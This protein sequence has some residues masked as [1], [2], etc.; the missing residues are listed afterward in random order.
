M[1]KVVQRLVFL[2]FA[3]AAVVA[4]T[5]IPICVLQQHSKLLGYHIKQY[6]GCL[7]FFPPDHCPKSEYYIIICNILFVWLF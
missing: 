6:F 2:M 5:Y 3:Y 7:M 4:L 1:N